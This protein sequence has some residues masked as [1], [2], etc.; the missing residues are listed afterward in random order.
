[1]DACLP[2]LDLIHCF[3]MDSLPDILPGFFVPR[4]QNRPQDP[5]MDTMRLE[6]EIRKKL[7]AIHPDHPERQHLLEHPLTSTGFLTQPKEK[8]WDPERLTT[9]SNKNSGKNNLVS[10]DSV[11]NLPYSR[12]KP[13]PLWSELED[14]SLAS[15]R[16]HVRPPLR[17]PYSPSIYVTCRELLLSLRLVLT[18]V[19]SPLYVWDIYWEKFLPKYASDE[20]D[21]SVIIAGTDEVV[22]SSVVGRFLRIGAALRRLELLVDS[23][24][25]SRGRPQQAQHSFVHAVSCVL[26]CLRQMLATSLAFGEDAGHQLEHDALA[27]LWMT[28]EDTE[29]LLNALCSLC[30]RSEHSIPVAYTPLPVTIAAILSQIYNSVN[31]HLEMRSARIITAAFSYI[32]TVTSQDY[33]R[34]VCQSVGYRANDSEFSGDMTCLPCP[35]DAQKSDGLDEEF[36]YNEDDET[37]NQEKFNMQA[38]PVFVHSY[39]D[40]LQRAQQSLRL[41]RQAQPDHPLLTDQQHNQVI[42][43]KWTHKDVTAAWNKDF[44]PFEDAQQASEQP[45]RS[46]DAFR[47]GN[48]YKTGLEGFSIF[49]LPPGS[50]LARASAPG[51]RTHNSALSE[52]QAFLED[53]PS[54]LPPI[55]P[56]LGHLT[57]LVLSPLVRHMN[58]LSGALVAIFLTPDTYLNLQLH[59]TLLRSYLLLT[60]HSFRSRLENALFSDSDEPASS[61][62][63]LRRSIGT[64]NQ[65]SSQTSDDTPAAQWAVGLSSQLTEGDSWPPRGADLSYHLRTVIVDALQENLQDERRRVQPSTTY[66]RL[67]QEAE[68]R[69]GFVLRDLSAGTGKERWLDPTS[70]E[71]MDFLYLD[72]LPP[73]PLDIIITPTILSKYYRILAF[74]LRLMRA[75][76][77][78]A[79][80]YR[81]TRKAS[82]PLFPTLT[83]SNKLLLHFRFVAHSF[84]TSLTSYVYDSA[85]GGNFD[86]FLLQLGPPD[87]KP[88]TKRPAGGFTDFASLADRHSKVLDDILSACLL[89]SGQK[90]VGELLRGCLALVL[91]LG[92]LAGLRHKK[93]MPEYE[94]ATRLEDL[95]NEFR[96]NMMTLIKVLRALIER[97]LAVHGSLDGHTPLLTSVEGVAGN[98]HDL[99]I[100]LDTA[101]WWTR[102]YDLTSIR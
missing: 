14:R 47:Q 17:D 5:I 51:W 87:E 8:P 102:K 91:E 84:V 89:R 1:M 56:T 55:T 61:L 69:L 43:W 94:A 53:Y 25:P 99:L 48:A 32:L 41:L 30:G 79:A 68:Y 97:N 64:I 92:I 45:D 101:Q 74:N 65:S 77:V 9:R 54:T 50:C 85:I 78:M 29:K 76:N 33:F 35:N 34:Q 59:L 96:K 36:L 63:R 81:M 28:Y 6:R 93:Q 44:D 18:G 90:A 3:N 71:A 38:H 49:D 22:S 40:V 31:S 86:A 7:T 23:Q 19:S 39:A 80:F 70:I 75:S 27:A 82:C 10:W 20:L 13:S 26:D 73:E 100:R 98:L 42:C 15:I 4:L 24:L 12:T 52:L 95:W 37:L 57:E 67:L 83:Q 58:R 11:R 66:E 88:S 72:Y 21:A 46:G 62:T 2:D 60:S 16:Y